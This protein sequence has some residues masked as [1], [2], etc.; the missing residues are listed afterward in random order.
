VVL[1]PAVAYLRVSGAGQEDKDGFTRQL[2]AITEYA[3]SHGY[4]ITETYQEVFTGTKDYDDR[5]AMR[6]MLA[7][8]ISSKAGIKT[9]IVEKVDRVARDLIVQESVIAKIQSYGMTLLSTCEPDL[10]SDDPSRV[11]IRQV[12]G[13]VAQLDR[14]LIVRKTRAARERIRNSGQRCEGRKPFGFRE[15]ER[16]VI[17]RILSMAQWSP[18]LIASELNFNE[19]KTRSGGKWT[20]VQVKRILEREKGATN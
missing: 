10:C 20:G 12:L 11:F 5:P 17:E 16:C 8:L 9:I 1:I 14:S 19:I 6:A 15:G 3:A 13:A 7:D 2:A 4:E 18:T